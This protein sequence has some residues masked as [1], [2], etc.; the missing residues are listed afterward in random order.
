MI[1]CK[2]RESLFTFINHDDVP[3]TNNLAENAFRHFTKY[4]QSYNGVVSINGIKRHLVLLS[5]YETGKN[6][7]VNF[8][9]FLL[10]RV[11]HIETYKEKYTWSGNRRKVRKKAV[12]DLPFTILQP[13]A[14]AN[15]S[16]S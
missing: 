2:H 4:R 12:S 15:N 5:I 3:W 7:D 13:P 16:I 1:R 8:L 14:H 10:S 9:R 11:K 6:R